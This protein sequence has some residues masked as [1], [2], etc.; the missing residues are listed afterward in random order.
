VAIPNQCLGLSTFAGSISKCPPN[1]NAIRAIVFTKCDNLSVVNGAATEIQISL[2][3]FFIPIGQAARTTFTVPAKPANNLPYDIYKLDLAG[4][5]V[6]GGV[7]F[8]ALFPQYGTTASGNQL[9]L[10][11]APE[12]GIEEGVL[13]T[14]APEAPGATTSFDFFQVNGLQFGWG[15]NLSYSGGTGPV[16][17]ATNGGLLRWDGSTMKLWNTLNSASPTDF[18]SSLAVD[19]SNNLWIG[20]NSGVITFNEVDGGSFGNYLAS[21]TG[22]P[23]NTINDIKLFPVNM[24]AA[25]TD[26]GLS[27]FDTKGI[28]FQNYNIY[29]S[30]LLKHNNL[31]KLEVSDDL[32]V[33]VG[34]TGGVYFFNTTNSAWGNYPLNSSTVAGWIAPNSVQSLASYSGTLYVGT[35]GGLVEIPYTGITGATFSP[36]SVSG[37]TILSGLTGPT[38]SNFT[39]LRV[40]EYGDIYLYAGHGNNTGAISVFNI[41]TDSWDYSLGVPG[42]SGGDIQ[43]VLPDYLSGATSGMTLFT[44]NNVDSG[45]YKIFTGN[46]SYDTVPGAGNNCNL[47]LSVPKGMTSGAYSVDSSQLYS[48]AQSLYF[49]FS[50]DMTGGATSG[51]SFENFVEVLNGVNGIGATLAGTWTWDSTGKIAEFQTTFQKAQGYNMRIAQGSTAADNS[52]LVEGMNVGFYTENISPVLGWNTLGK[53]LVFSGTDTNLVESIYLRN[54]Q[55]T[56]INVI[57]LIGGK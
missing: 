51:I 14:G 38:S 41:T 28:T 13:F 5:D 35:T 17:A 25:A 42:L 52:Y 54:P 34:T 21:A 32:I 47:L 44:G 1:P 2:T 56:D 45:I 48:T 27:L 26:S 53:M 40:E 24:V 19:S 43:D 39:S 12:N 18:M 16:Y 31:V 50:K 29:N 46:S 8:I 15:G 4:I 30:P 7:K 36:G 9:Y 20:S 55:S 57:A 6:D 11:W 23:S 37:T 49:L 33:F 22:L 10:E 3:P